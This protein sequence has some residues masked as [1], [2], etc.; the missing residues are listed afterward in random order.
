MPKLVPVWLPIASV[1]ADR[2]TK[3]NRWLLTSKLPSWTSMDLIIIL[4]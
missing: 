1:R 4:C 2:T 3:G